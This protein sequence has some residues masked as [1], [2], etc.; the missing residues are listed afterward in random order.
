MVA[1]TYE[2]F[3]PAQIA[4]ERVQGRALWEGLAIQAGWLLVWWIVA[5]VMWARG[6]NR[7]QAVGG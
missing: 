1:V 2:L 4:M 5:R 6:V 3:F 7:Y